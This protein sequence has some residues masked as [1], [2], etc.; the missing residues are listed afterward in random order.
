MAKNVSS[1]EENVKRKI[2]LPSTYP[3]PFPFFRREFIVHAYDFLYNL[4]DT[5]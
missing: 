1:T 5:S 2:S 4:Y 3:H